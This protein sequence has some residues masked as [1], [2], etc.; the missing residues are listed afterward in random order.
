MAEPAVEFE[1]VRTT[2]DTV[3][4]GRGL[5][6]NVWYLLRRWPIIPMIVL[7]LLVIGALFAP[8]L[9][10]LDPIYP[11]LLDAN[12]P[13]FWLSEGS[14]EHPLGTDN[15][16][17]DVFSRLLFGARISLMVV[18]VATLSSMVVGTVAGM[19][20][21]YAGGNIDE[22]IMRAVDIWYAVPFIMVA[23]VLVVVFGKSTGMMIILLL[24]LAWTGGVRNVRAEVLTLKEF[25]YVAA[26]RIAGAGPSRILLRHIL[27][28]VFNT[29]L[30]IVTLRVGAL[31]LAESTLSFLGAGIPAPQPAWGVMVADGRDYLRQAW[32]IS[33]IPGVAIFLVVMSFN[34]SG[35]WLRDRL[36]PRLRQID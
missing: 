23:L 25:D 16:G 26:A 22:I 28:G 36:D 35:D 29:V 13:P 3:V 18:I 21:G 15:I 11:D 4:P 8:L 34:F 7:A 33:T 32:W 2:P 14:M 12:T 27:P 17:R 30:V 9:T 24:L 5:V 1:S 10:P 31:I 19:V 6:G 20:A